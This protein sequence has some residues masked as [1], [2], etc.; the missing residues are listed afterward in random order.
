MMTNNCVKCDAT[1]VEAK[2]DSF[3][4]SVYKATVKPNKETMSKI[5]P[6]FVCPKCGFIE[7]YAS[8]PGKFT[9]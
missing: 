6:C 7:L 2:L 4:V 1:M 5:D 9:E 3:P 8:A